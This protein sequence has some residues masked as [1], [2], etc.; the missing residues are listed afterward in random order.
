M[1]RKRKPKGA[2]SQR[3]PDVMSNDLPVVGLASMASGLMMWG[4]F[5]P[6]QWGWL[7]WLAPLGWLIVVTHPRSP[8]RWGYFVLWLSGCLFWLLNLHSIRLAFW[9]LVFGWLALSLYLAVYTPLFV[10]IARSLRWRWRWPLWIVAPVVWVGMDVARSFIITGYAAGQLGHS[11]AHTP[12]M[13]QI[14]DQLGGYGVT[15]VIVL[16]SAAGLEIW[17]SFRNRKW[18]AATLP[19]AMAVVALAGTLAYGGW[20]LKQ[21][22]ALAA[23]SK[24]LLQVALIQENTP[25]IFDMHSAERSVEAWGRYR[26]ATREAA[27]QHG[28]VDLVVWPESTFTA[29]NPWVESKLDQALPKSLE[30][31]GLSWEDFNRN[32]QRMESE[33]QWKVQNVLAAARNV[34]YDPAATTGYT[35]PHLL[36]GCDAL[37][38]SSLDVENYNSALFFAPDGSYRDRY[39][40]MHLVMFGEYIPLGPLLKWLAN[41]FGMGRI[42]AGEQVK[43]FEVQG[44][45]IA[46]SICFESMLPELISWQLRKLRQQSLAPDIL[47]NVTN[48]SWFRGTSMLDHHLGCSIMCAVENRRPMLIAANTGLTAAVDGAGRIQAV[49]QRL[50]RAVLM[51][52][53]YA[54]GR[55]GLVQW[56][57]Y[58][59]AWL[60]CAISTCGL[61]GSMRI[62]QRSINAA[63]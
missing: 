27:I 53:P 34:D 29:L 60:C 44:V 8:G 62:R 42:A 2:A 46:P 50:Q 11:Q 61:I 39:D 18:A 22:D 43:C 35:K 31:E 56:M 3:G 23:S 48:D 58:P 45:R 33:F 55:Q 9:A 25:S 14:A 30:N 16:V 15:F 5:A 63:T 49:S 37:K 1:N 17:S 24:P 7:A 12:L 28:L 59:L 26:D 19:A 13:I 52:K 21:T 40:K 57:G 51:G 32:K 4:S 47:I 10:G 36:L 41:A 38:L 54:D 20:R 6:L